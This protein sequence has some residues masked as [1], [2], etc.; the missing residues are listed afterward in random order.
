MTHGN[1][2]GEQGSPGGNPFGANPFGQQPTT[3]PVTTA[4]PPPQTNT[5][6]TL[7]VVFA[8]LFAP[9]GAVL[10]H[11]GL[12]QSNRTGGQGR[13]R[14]LVGLT[15]SYALITII[16]VALAVWAV[17][18]FGSGEPATPAA[19]PTATS[20]PASTPAPTTTTTPKPPPPPKVDAAGLP[21]LVI[22]LDEIKT[23][24]K[25]PDLADGGASHTIEGP[26]PS[27]ARFEP[28]EC[29]SSFGP[30]LPVAYQDS[31]YRAV[32]ANTL[33]Q[34]PRPSMQVAQGLATFDDAAAAQKALANYIE[35]WRKC[36]GR[37]FNWITV[38]DGQVATFT[39]G[40]PEDGGDGVTALRS[41]NPG[42][43]VSSTRAIAAR[44]NVLVDIWILG[45]AVSD[46]AT[47]IAKRILARIPGQ[48]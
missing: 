21:A 15:L 47:T 9:V 19:P 7:S 35:L 43:P 46:E 10:G 37:T 27:V 32:L 1:H 14:A 28:P 18:G 3:P 17:T 2:S 36:A 29:M 22:G 13:D 34:Q 48:K 38:A 33:V 40:A 30:Q 20:A 26:P 39:L 41:I 11:L 25:N 5:F 16:V 4:P 42:S 24:T 6:A 23:L 8:F 31:G 12:R 45:S 44:N